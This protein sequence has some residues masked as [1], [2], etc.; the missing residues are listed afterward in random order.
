MTFL[1]KNRFDE[2]DYYISLLPLKISFAVSGII[3]L[4]P[5][6]HHEQNLANKNEWP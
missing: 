6:Y 1:L 3:N 5:Y 4:P 2:N